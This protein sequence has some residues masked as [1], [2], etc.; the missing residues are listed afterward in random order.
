MRAI[1]ALITIIYFIGVGVALAPTI[2]TKWSRATAADLTAS[3]AQALPT[4][5]AWP[6]VVAR[7]IADKG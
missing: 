4:A 6:A 3:A 7:S 5:F 2:Q 1:I